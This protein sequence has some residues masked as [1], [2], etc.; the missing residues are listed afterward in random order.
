MANNILKKPASE[1]LRQVASDERDTKLIPKNEYKPNSFE[2]GSTNPNAVSDG[3]NKG[4][5]DLGNGTVGNV[6]DIEE[7]SKLL[8]VNNYKNT[9]TYPDSSVL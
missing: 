4:K 9:N 6:T 7:R 5:G 2:Y 3:D 8:A 1:Q